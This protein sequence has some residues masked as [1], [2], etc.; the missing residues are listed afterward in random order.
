[1][2]MMDHP[3]LD[4]DDRTPP[5]GVADAARQGLAL[6]RQHGRG[7]TDV[8]VRRAEQLSQR[9]TVSDRD[10]KSMYSYFAR[11]TV[12]KRARAWAD[13]DK[14]STGYIAWMLWGG[15]EAEAWISTLRAQLRDVGI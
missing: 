9:L 5:E 15:D 13:P 3:I 7:G 14:P 1:M 8:G 4:E 6:R 12:D 10:I 11:H 2:L